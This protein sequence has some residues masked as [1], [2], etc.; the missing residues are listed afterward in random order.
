MAV[1]RLK[2]TIWQKVVTSIKGRDD[3]RL[4]WSYIFLISDNVTNSNMLTVL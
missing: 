2:G 3:K 1:T 4:K